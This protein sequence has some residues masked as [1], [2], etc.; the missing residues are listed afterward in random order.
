MGISLHNCPDSK[1]EILHHFC[2][3]RLRRSKHRRPTD[4]HWQRDQRRPPMANRKIQP[5]SHNGQ[6]HQRW[7][8]RRQSLQNLLQ[9]KDYASSRP[10]L[11]LVYSRLVLRRHH[12]CWLRHVHHRCPGAELLS[13]LGRYR[14]YSCELQDQYE[15]L[16][17]EV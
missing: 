11:Q 5:N 6:T 9:T 13:I 12:R 3:R 1:G 17:C 4:L 8:C 7:H 14:V 2:P 16:G 10:R 15:Q